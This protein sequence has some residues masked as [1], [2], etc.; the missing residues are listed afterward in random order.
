M[1]LVQ[2]T[3]LTLVHLLPQFHYDPARGRFR[4]Y[5]LTIVHRKGLAVLRRGARQAAVPLEEVE[6]VVAQEDEGDRTARWQEALLDEAWFQLKASGRLK[7]DTL[8]AFEAYAIRGE[9]AEEVG[10]R[11]GLSANT[12]YQIKNR[13]IGLLREE[14]QQRLA[15]LDPDD[16]AVWAEAVR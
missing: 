9:A 3:L 11:H 12:V 8:A 1:T 15:D 2:E 6:R 5:L 4:N 7:P 13:V 10:R 14:V 16:P